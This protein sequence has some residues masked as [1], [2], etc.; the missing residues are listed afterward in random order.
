M[1]CLVLAALA[2]CA[3]APEATTAK[4]E[5][6]YFHVN[7]PRA[8]EVTLVVIAQPPAD[9]V[10]FEISSVKTKTGFWVSFLKLPPGNYRYFFMVDG[11]PTVESSM[12]RLMVDD[13]GGMS[14]V[15]RVEKTS[16]GKLE[17]Y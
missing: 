16:D 5:H 12:E 10:L 4:D 14:G 9:P 7:A 17:T 2:G 11:T 15:I 3:A 1:I 8:S 13:F 6:V